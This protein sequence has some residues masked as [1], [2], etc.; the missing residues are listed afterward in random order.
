MRRRWRGWPTTCAR[1]A[2]SASGRAR[3]RRSSRGARRSPRCSATRWT[4]RPRRGGG[5]RRR[6]PALAYL[7]ERGAPIVIKADGLALGKGVTVAMTLAEAEAAVRD[8]FAGTFGASGSSVVIEEFL[9][10]EEASVF[11]VSRRRAVRDAG[12]G[13]GP[14]AGVRRRQGPEHRRHGLVLAGAGDDARRC[15]GGRW[16]RSSRRPS[17]A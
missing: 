11:A 1:R 13:A 6:R 8:C 2:S 5:S 17:R 16:T 15:C 12:D 10:G 7:R 4:S 3:R 9:E 14:Q